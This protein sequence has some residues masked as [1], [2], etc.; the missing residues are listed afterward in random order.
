MNLSADKK[1]LVFLGTI[2]TAVAVLLIIII[3][4]AVQNGGSGRSAGGGESG[5]ENNVP[6]NLLRINDMYQ[7]DRTIP[8]YD[9]PVNNYE[10]D[11]FLKASS[12][13]KIFYGEA[14]VGIDVSDH[15]QEIDW[16]KVKESGID[17]AIIRLGYRGFT[18]GGL[19]ADSR[20]IANITGAL[21]NGIEVGVYFFSQAT[22]EE[23]AVEEAA[24]VLEQVG[25]YNLTYPIYYDWEPITE[26]DEAAVP[27]TQSC[28]GKDVTA[29]TVAF[30]EE[31]KKAG[32][33][34]GYYTN[35]TMGYD[36]YNLEELQE[37]DIWYAEYQDV[38]SFYYNFEMWQYSESGVISGIPVE[39][40]LNL[41][42]KTYK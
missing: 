6:E 31:I 36:F 25:N 11:K 23:E 17:Y 10:T 5:V 8:K 19:I 24:Y 3:V 34:P 2:L 22:S 33:Y 38:P 29:F 9:I 30:C 21:E 4:M 12:N 7:G 16:V 13:G 18:E 26:H 28:T 27:R 35:K 41:S 37:Y 15:Q 39:V 14:A 1:R 40:D 42:L 20:F 32:F